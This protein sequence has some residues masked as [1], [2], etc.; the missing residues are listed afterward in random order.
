RTFPST[1]RSAPSRFTTSL[2]IGPRT[3]QRGN[4]YSPTIRPGCSN[5]RRD[6]ARS[7]TARRCRARGS[8]A[9]VWGAFK[10]AASPL[11][12]WASWGEGRREQDGVWR[13][14]RDRRKINGVA[15]VGPGGGVPAGGASLWRSPHTRHAGRE[16]GA[17]PDARAPARGGGPGAR[18]FVRSTTQ[19]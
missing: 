10:F 17:V 11:P 8:H 5:F 1:I 6:A 12:L 15:T 18:G 7:W 9:E 4:A 19:S 2:W 16:K 13:P 14:R 3:P